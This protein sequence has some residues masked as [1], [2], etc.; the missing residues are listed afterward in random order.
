[1]THD[2]WQLFAS[3]SCPACHVTGKVVQDE[4]E[5]YDEFESPFVCCACGQA[6]RDAGVVGDVKDYR[7][8]YMRMV[9]GRPY[10]PPKPK[11]AVPTKVD[12]SAY[13][14][15]LKDYYQ[16]PSSGPTVLDLVNRAKAVA[17][18]WHKPAEAYVFKSTDGA[19]VWHSAQSAGNALSMDTWKLP[20]GA[21]PTTMRSKVLPTGDI[22]TDLGGS[23]TIQF[24]DNSD[25]PW[26]SWLFDADTGASSTGTS[27]PTRSPRSDRPSDMRAGR[28]P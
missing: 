10:E 27:R 19:P 23:A 11:E 2:P 20:D 6:W 12:L 24:K 25:P 7:V 22:V 1:M 15:V 4:G 5:A 14:G 8:Q 3:L 28:R 9:E 17:E 13:D 21:Q 26:T 18:S 16:R